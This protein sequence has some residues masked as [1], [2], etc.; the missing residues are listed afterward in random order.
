MRVISSGERASRSPQLISSEIGHFALVI[1][2][3]A[4]RPSTRGGQCKHDSQ[5]CHPERYQG[6][7]DNYHAPKAAEK[8]IRLDDGPCH[9]RSASPYRQHRQQVRVDIRLAEAATAA[10]CCPI[11]E[12]V[13]TKNG[14][15]AAISEVVFVKGALIHLASPAVNHRTIVRATISGA[16]R[17]TK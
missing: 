3:I 7:F 4:R 17:W 11:A 12:Q 13:R 5:S 16:S 14:C 10:T 8:Q 15:S 2:Q 6:T 9:R 1:L